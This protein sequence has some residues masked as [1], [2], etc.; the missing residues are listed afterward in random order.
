MIKQLLVAGATAAMLSVGTA[1]AA[2]INLT[3]VTGLW[4]AT[5]PVF[6]DVTGQNT[7]EIRWGVPASSGGQSGYRF[8]SAATPAL[9]NEDVAFNLGTFTHFNYP[10]YE[11]ALTSAQ[12]T[13]HS[14]LEID[15]VE[16]TVMSVFEFLHWETPNEDR[17]CANGGANY[18][19]V[20][21]N[22]CADRVT[23]ALNV[24]ASDSFLIGGVNYFVDI[25]GFFYDGALADEFWTKEKKSNTAMLKGLIT[26]RPVS[27]P[28]PSTLALLGL[29]LLGLGVRR[30]VRQA[31]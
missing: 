25:A 19:G 11:P 12:L 3:S 29:G 21:I 4:T 27:V 23:F 20:N 8:D 10:I 15:G 30:K 26:S 18:S 13:V 7:N 22:G 9:V 17:T 24:G 5:T 28:E 14:T 6:P 2:V 31:A 1:S 16:E